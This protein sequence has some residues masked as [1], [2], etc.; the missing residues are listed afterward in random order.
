[1]RTVNVAAAVIIRDGKI[2]V[3]QGIVAG[4]A[5]GG[6]ENICAVAD[7]LD[8][9]SIGDGKFTLSVYP[10]SVPIYMELIRNGCAAKLMETGTVIKT[11][12]CGPCFG[13]G[14]TPAGA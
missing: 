9:K 1:M 5:G 14:D 10:A 7:I 8:G 3:D 2:F 11:A 6:F 4:C 12:F 13:V